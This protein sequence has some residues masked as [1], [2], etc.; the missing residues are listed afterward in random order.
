MV[1]LY[2]SSEDCG[3][4]M[5]HSS[6]AA[7]TP[8]S[9]SHVDS[10]TRRRRPL[11]RRPE[12]RSSTASAAIDAITHSTPSTITASFRV[13]GDVMNRVSTSIVALS[14]AVSGGTSS[15]VNTPVTC[16]RFSG[17]SVP[18]APGMPMKSAP[19]WPTSAHSRSALHAPASTSARGATAATVSRNATTTVSG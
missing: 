4:T 18:V 6:S 8:A 9:A 16:G 3:P 10:P 11:R 12:A 19:T 15:S 13:V 7:T 2:P 17:A 1:V 14:P 5:C